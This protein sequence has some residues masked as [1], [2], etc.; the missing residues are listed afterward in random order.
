MVQQIVDHQ[1]RRT[2]PAEMTNVNKIE[3]LGLEWSRE[4]VGFLPPRRSQ[5]YWAL[6]ARECCY[7]NMSPASLVFARSAF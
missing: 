5:V 1:I 3:D 6:P 4:L 7:Q 2:H